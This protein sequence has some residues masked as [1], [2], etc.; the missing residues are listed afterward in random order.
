MKS[1]CS[2]VIYLQGHLLFSELLVPIKKTTGSGALNYKSPPA[3][4]QLGRPALGKK[5]MSIS[6]NNSGLTWMLGS[7]MGNSYRARRAQAL[8][9]TIPSMGRLYVYL[10]TLNG[11]FL[12]VKC[13]EIYHTLT[14]ILWVYECYDIPW[15]VD[16][17]ITILKLANHNP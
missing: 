8:P 11:C 5:R 12:M 15:Q 7:V 1:T 17:V 4:A 16:W 9:M 3:T 10:P 6:S 2:S 14:W 13:R